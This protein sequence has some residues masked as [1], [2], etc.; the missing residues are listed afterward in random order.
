MTLSL[1]AYTLIL[2]LFRDILNISYNLIF[3][4]IDMEEERFVPQE[5]VESQPVEKP[6]VK[7]EGKEKKFKLPQALWDYIREQYHDYD[8]DSPGRERV[9][10]DIKNF[11]PDLTES[12][13][14]NFGRLLSQQGPYRQSYDRPAYYKAD[15]TSY[16]DAEKFFEKEHSG[17]KYNTV[18]KDV[19]GILLKSEARSIIGAFGERYQETGK[20]LDVTMSDEGFHMD[21]AFDRM[22]SPLT[23]LN[24]NKE[25]LVK[26]EA[27]KKELS[28]ALE[29]ANRYAGGTKEQKQKEKAPI[30]ARLLELSKLRKAA[31]AEIG[32]SE[33][34]LYLVPGYHKDLEAQKE[35]SA[36]SSETFNKKDFDKDWMDKNLEKKLKDLRKKVA[37][38]KEELDKAAGKALWAAAEDAEETL[39]K[40]R[41]TDKE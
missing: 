5:A 21:K 33:T 12:D 24:E 10:K 31:E 9:T 35:K 41:A 4:V 26:Y 17:L 36:E 1:S 16:Y 38:S 30:E 25:L 40:K 8:P 28:A 20:S 22:F 34:V 3:K 11:Y 32:K 37:P 18:V 27:E 6:E 23:K 13:L 15:R 7:K 2:A 14:E 29:K 39:K 19:V